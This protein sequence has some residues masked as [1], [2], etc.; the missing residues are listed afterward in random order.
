MILLQEDLIVLHLLHEWF[1]WRAW[2]AAEGVPY[3]IM[4]KLLAQS[5][6]QLRLDFIRLAQRAA[7]RRQMKLLGILDDWCNA[8]IGCQAESAFARA[9]RLIQPAENP[10][11]LAVGAVSHVL[12]LQAV[13]PEG[14]S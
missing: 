4:A 11:A 5:R 7:L 13:R 10:A 14:M 2:N 3:R 9:D 6:F 1:F 12:A 8:V